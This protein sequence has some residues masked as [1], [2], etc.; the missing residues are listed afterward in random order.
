M[1]EGKISD[2]VKTALPVN[3]PFSVAC[4]DD[5]DL[6]LQTLKDEIA[7]PQKCTVMVAPGEDD[8]VEFEVDVTY[9]RNDNPSEN[10]FFM[11][12]QARFEP[13][14]EK[15]LG[16]L[17]NK[18]GATLTVLE[19]PEGTLVHGIFTIKEGGSIICNT[20]YTQKGEE[21]TQ[22]VEIKSTPDSGVFFQ[23]IRQR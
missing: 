12:A 6:S 10:E 15:A 5:L 13:A 20:L 21:Y 7:N 19:C 16:E 18:S 2:L 9:P 4:P 3:T 17:L 22:N 8:Q 11:D 14:I 1:V 23:M